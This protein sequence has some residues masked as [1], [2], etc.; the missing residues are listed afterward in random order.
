MR[1]TSCHALAW[2]FWHLVALQY[3]SCSIKP[4]WLPRAERIVAYEEFA[5]VLPGS[6]CA[7]YQTA[8]KKS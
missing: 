8:L 3:I 6:W 1:H 4:Y 7:V 5:V 2:A